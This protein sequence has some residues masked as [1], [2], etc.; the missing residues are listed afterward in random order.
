M[1]R[2][3]IIIANAFKLPGL[4]TP[5]LERTLGDNMADAA[6]KGG[7]DANGIRYGQQ[8]RRLP[9][10]PP[11]AGCVMKP[12]GK[13]AQIIA[14]LIE[15]GRPLKRS[16][17]ADEMGVEPDSFKD[18]LT[19]LRKKEIIAADDL[20]R[21]VFAYRYIGAAKTSRKA[22]EWAKPDAQAAQ[23]DQDTQGRATGENVGVL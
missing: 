11:Q 20:G 19:L 16:D 13:A 18:V 23:V 15:A 3:Q 21:N 1:T 4:M 5:A 7:I 14:I 8:F 12:T 10:N 9:I 6:R 22:R 17:I 2:N